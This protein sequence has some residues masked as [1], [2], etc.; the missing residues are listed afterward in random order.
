MTLINPLKKV[1][2]FFLCLWFNFFFLFI[3]EVREYGIFLGLSLPEDN[4][5]LYIAKE[6]LMASVPKPWVV[7]INQKQD[8]FYL[9]EAKSL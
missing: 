6:G 8:I 7:C 9:M 3:L 5:L 1:V 2:L 4:N